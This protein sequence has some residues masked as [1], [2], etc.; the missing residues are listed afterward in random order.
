LCQ[1]VDRVRLLE[2]ELQGA[3]PALAPGGVMRVALP[4]AVNADSLATWFAPAIAAFAANAPVLVELEID[5]QD[6]T[7]E[8]L[9]SGKVLAAVTGTGR[10]AAGCN[11]RPLGAMRYLAAAS[12]AFVACHFA[13]GI[14]A[15]SLAQAPSLVFNPKDDLQARWVRRLC[16][17]DVELPRHTVPSPQAFVTAAVVGMGWGL[18]P[19][20]LIAKHLDDGSLVELLPNSPLDVPLYWQHARAASTLLDGL[21]REVAVAAARA[22]LPP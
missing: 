11:S 8:W 5:D 10:A 12:P 9:R 3:L 16:H 18:Q 7:T 21:S 4:I 13:N 15:G 17:R 2:Q 19:V 22:L 20:A 14:G 1:H 6:H